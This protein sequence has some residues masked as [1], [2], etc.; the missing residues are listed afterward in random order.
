MSRFLSL[1]I[2]VVLLAGSA[3]T[4]PLGLGRVAEPDEIAAWDIDVRPDGTG[5]P[6]GSGSVAMGEEVFVEKCAA[7]HGDFAEGVGRYPALAGGLDTLQDERPMRTVGSFWPYLSTTYDFINRAMTVGYGEPASDDEIYAI[8]AYILYS[9]D[10]VDDD[11]VLSRENFTSIRLPNEGGF[12]MDDRI[13]TEHPQFTRPACMKN[14]KDEVQIIARV[15]TAFIP[16]DMNGDGTGKT[17]LAIGEALFGQCRACH[18][19][20]DGAQNG[21]GPVLNGIFG[22]PAGSN[23]GF[24]YS[25]AFA[26]MVGEELVWDFDALN[27]FLKDPQGFIPGT[28]M[29]FTGIE[30]DFDRNAL[31][32]YLQAQGP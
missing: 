5:L 22:K 15:E 7:C 1:I 24:G 27:A 6:V 13:Q 4:E 11:F 18:Q 12:Y 20:G 9:N 8:I 17:Q 28:T 16:A 3:W 31:I 2:G 29:N 25:D 14:C 32:A 30:E 23:D 21:V 19:I 26:M 10:L